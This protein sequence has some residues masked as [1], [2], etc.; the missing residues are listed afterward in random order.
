MLTPSIIWYELTLC[1][2]KTLACQLLVKLSH[3]T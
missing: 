3:N 1:A 2:L